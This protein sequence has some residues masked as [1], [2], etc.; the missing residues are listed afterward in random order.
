MYQINAVFNKQCLPDML[1][2]LHEKGVEGLTISEV[3]G[4]D[5]YI[6]SDDGSPSDPYEKVMA[7]V[8]VPDEKTKALVMEAI[9]A[10]AHDLGHGA[11]KMWVTPVLE[12]ERIRTGE[13]DEAA[14]QPSEKKVE[15]H[16]SDYF[17]HEDTPSS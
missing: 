15:L 10:N 2:E 3:A 7:V 4:R 5:S 6:P 1:E 9:R 8:L 11:G 17:T 14:L 16:E 13:K 12:V